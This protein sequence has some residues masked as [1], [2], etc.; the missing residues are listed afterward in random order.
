MVESL[1]DER[2][3]GSTKT[4]DDEAIYQRPLFT[5]VA[6]YIAVPCPEKI[7]EEASP[8]DS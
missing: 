8:S 2:P 6:R 7:T 4:R 1:R 3:L 5:K